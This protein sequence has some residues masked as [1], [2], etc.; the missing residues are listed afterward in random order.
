MYVDTKHLWYYKLLLI[1]TLKFRIWY[2]C[3]ALRLKVLL[4]SLRFL[5]GNSVARFISGCSSLEVLTLD[6]IGFRGGNACFYSA[7][8][9]ELTIIDTFCSVWIQVDSP[10]L[11]DVTFLYSDG[12]DFW[13]DYRPPLAFDVLKDPSSVTYLSL[14]GSSLGVCFIMIPLFWFSFFEFLHNFSY[15]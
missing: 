3:H 11:S 1:W 5:D 8:L 14:Q 15:N 6:D 9:K 2:V 10:R 13:Y 12:T 7:T 4:K